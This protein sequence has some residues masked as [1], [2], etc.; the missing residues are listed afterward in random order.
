MPRATTEDFNRFVTHC[1]KKVP[2]F[3]VHDGKRDSYLMNLIDGIVYPFNKNFMSDYITTIIGSVFFPKGF[4]KRQP[5]K[6]IE[7]AGHEFIHAYDVKR[8][9]PPIFIATYLS[10]VSVFLLAMVVYGIF[11]CWAAFLPFGWAV[12]HMAAVA[13][14]FKTRKVTGFP[15]LALSLLA[16]VALSAWLD[17]WGA[18]WLASSLV[19]LAPIPAPGR[20]WAEHRGY[21]G[22]IAFELA[23]YGRTDIGRKVRQFTGPN[24]YWMWPFTSWVAAKLEIYKTRANKGDGYDP[25]FAHVL[26]FIR[27]LIQ[28]ETNA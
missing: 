19:F 18:L 4:I 24:Y 8:V 10:F 26:H 1:Q 9:T 16:A 20:Y 21:G 7:V 25:A 27:D 13:I 12:I 15:L 28:G 6:A 3:T 14:S 2:G 22:S 17:G 5:L 23:L 11:G